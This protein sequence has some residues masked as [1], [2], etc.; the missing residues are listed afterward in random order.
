MSKILGIDYGS[1]RVGLA[2]GDEEQKIAL[3]FDVLPNNEGFVGTLRRVIEN[4][5]IYRLVV[6]V[7]FTMQG[8][9][10]A[11]TREA[12]EFIDMLERNFNM[13]ILREDE[14]LSSKMADQ[15][16]KDYRQKYDRDA[17][18]A[19]IILQGYLDKIK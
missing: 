2:L 6:G 1:Q 19:M 11:K 5:K 13:P 4:E 17:I 8:G 7:P 12:E 9:A 16:F 18:A 10:S 3:P 15:L 14:R